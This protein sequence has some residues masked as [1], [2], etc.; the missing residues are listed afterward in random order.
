MSMDLYR[1]CRQANYKNYY[2]IFIIFYL[3]SRVDF[4]ARRKFDITFPNGATRASR[5]DEGVAP[6]EPVSSVG[7]NCIRPLVNA[8]FRSTIV[9]AHI[10]RPP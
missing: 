8:I 1:I 9:G 5:S 7:A 2:L 10:M 3:L 4:T 6:Y